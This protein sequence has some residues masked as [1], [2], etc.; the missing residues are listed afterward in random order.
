[1]NRPGFPGDSVVVVRTRR[2]GAFFQNNLRPPHLRQEGNI[3]STT[4]AV[5]YCPPFPQSKVPDDLGLLEAIDGL[6]QDVT[7]GV[8]HG[9]G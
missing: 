2:A 6:G 8:P 1:M 3:Q 7:L 5:C 9:S 4:S